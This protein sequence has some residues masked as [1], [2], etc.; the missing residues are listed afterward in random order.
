PRLFAKT[1]SA[2]NSIPTCAASGSW[3]KALVKPSAWQ[4]S[5]SQLDMNWTGLDIFD[6]PIDKTNAWLKELMQELN[7][8]DRRRAFHAL[9]SVL[10][11]IRDRVSFE[12]SATFG[13]QLPLLIRGAY[14]ENWK[15]VSNPA[16]WA[17][18]E[19]EFIIRAA[20]RLLQRKVDAGEME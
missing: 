17:P 2:Q 20:F 16:S 19:D 6:G 14:F 7:W 4:R 10:H 11:A 1:W 5:C 15:P 13:N 3:S 8:T 12:N 9:C 18:P